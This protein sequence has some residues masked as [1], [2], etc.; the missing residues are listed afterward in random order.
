MKKTALILVVAF[1]LLPGLAARAQDLLRTNPNY[2]RARQL[3]VQAQQA[4]A[5][6]E[7]DKS[8]E[9]A[10]EAKRLIEVAQ[11]EA[12]AQR[13]AFQAT[14]WKNRAEERLRYAE[15]VGAPERFPDEWADANESY[16]RARTA[17]DNG[18]YQTAVDEARRVLAILEDV[19]PK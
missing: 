1:I 12:G 5:R 19:T 14:N 7:Y 17:Y 10:E 6:G 3:Q 9:Y 13:L 15:G 16:A 18:D 2:L 8:V 11:T 4:Y